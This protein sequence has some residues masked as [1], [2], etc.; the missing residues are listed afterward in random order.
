M[1]KIG[2]AVEYRMID[3]HTGEFWVPATIIF[4]DDHQICVQ[5]ADHV[6]RAIPLHS[7]GW[8]LATKLST[9]LARPG[10]IDT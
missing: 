9:R 10:L 6:R 3:R 7:P 2:D 5:A 4:I 1:G 8:R